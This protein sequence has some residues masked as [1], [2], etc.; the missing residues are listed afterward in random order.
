VLEIVRP[1][2][3]DSES[4]EKQE[5]TGIVRIVCPGC[6]A[7]RAPAKRCIADPGPP[8][9]E[10]VPGLQRTTS[11]CAAP[12]TRER[13]A[14]WRNEPNGHFGETKPTIIWPS[15][16][17]A[18]AGTHDLR[19]WLWVPTLAA[20]AGTPIA[21]SGRSTNLRLW[22]TNAGCAPLFPVVI[23]NEW[24]N[25]NVSGHRRAAAAPVPGRALRV[26]SAVTAYR[27]NR[28]RGRP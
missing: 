27:L 9:T 23:Y 25:S 16:V 8:Q 7:A 3:E 6:D 26:L 20:L 10:T 18:K 17:P 5:N 11:C 14:F 28:S 19:R 2:M 13:D 12:G 1:G 15:V 4:A 22:E 21:W 24:C